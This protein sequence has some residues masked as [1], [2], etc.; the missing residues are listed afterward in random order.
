MDS[1]KNLGAFKFKEET[2]GEVNLSHGNTT[3][4]VVAMET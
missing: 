4:V 1:N 2:N 3:M